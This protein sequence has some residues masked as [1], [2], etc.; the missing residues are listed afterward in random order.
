[1]TTRT[2][3]SRA[4][5][6]QRVAFQDELA[7][8]T[9]YIK[10]SSCAP[11]LGGFRLGFPESRSKFLLLEDEGNGRTVARTTDTDDYM[12]PSVL[13]SW[14]WVRG[15]DAIGDVVRGLRLAILQR[16]P[17]TF[18]FAWTDTATLSHFTEAAKRHRTTRTAD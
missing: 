9:E 5:V 4:T 14:H 7:A 12:R 6:K 3:E 17:L 2:N 18:P 1:M 10:A 11:H 13:R 8:V 15:E 16:V